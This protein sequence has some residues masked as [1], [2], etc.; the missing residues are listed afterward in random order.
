MFVYLFLLLKMKQSR[1]LLAFGS[2]T[3]QSRSIAHGMVDIAREQH[4][5]CADV[6]ELDDVDTQVRRDQSLLNNSK[7]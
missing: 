6:Y 4:E 7:I 1:F 5:I 2:E 3:G